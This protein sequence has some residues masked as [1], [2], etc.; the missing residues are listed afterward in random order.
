VPGVDLVARHPELLE[1]WK[2]FAREFD[3]FFGLEAATNEGLAAVVKDTTVER[4]TEAIAVAREAGFGVTGNFVIDP[5]WGES[6]FERL[7]TFIEQQ[8]LW[9][10]GFTILTPLPGTEYYDQMKPAIGGREWA[11]FD[12]HHLLWEPKLGGQRFFELYCETWRRS[13]LNLSGRKRWWQWMSDVRLK[14]ALFLSRMLVRT[15][16]MMDPKHYLREHPSRSGAVGET[17]KTSK[18]SM[19]SKDSR[20]SSTSQRC[21]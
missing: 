1:A 20:H 3:I 17:S 11:H 14:D 16:H 6:D 21:A 8:K 9:Q 10:A 2:P 5:A 7:W 4:T 19:D 18:A 15:Q 13:V 12:M